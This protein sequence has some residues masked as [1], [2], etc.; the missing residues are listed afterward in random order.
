MAQQQ[1]IIELEK[2]IQ[3]KD[4]DRDAEIDKKIEARIKGVRLEMK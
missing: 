1:K 3:Q 2:L 4:K